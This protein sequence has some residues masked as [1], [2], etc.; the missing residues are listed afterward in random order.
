MVG[1]VACTPPTTPLRAGA[2][3]QLVAGGAQ[4]TT[5]GYQLGD[6]I[7]VVLHD[8]ANTPIA[9]APIHVS[10]DAVLGAVTVIDALTRADGTARLVWRLGLTVG[11]QQLVITSGAAA[12]ATPLTVSAS[13][14]S[15]AMRAI[16]GD[17][18]VF[19][20][21]DAGGRLGCWGP[22]EQVDQ[23]PRWH[24]HPG[25]QRFIA[26]AVHPRA[27]G[28]RRGC[29][30]EDTGRVWCFDVL[31]DATIAALS[32]MPGT[33]LPLVSVTTGSGSGAM[34]PPFCGL[35]S[36]G[37]AFC[38]GD[39][40][41]GTLGD[42]SET[43]RDDVA[44]VATLTRFDRIGVGTAHACATARDG[45]GWCWGR[46][47]MS[48]VGY[49][50]SS[51]PVS[52]PVR[53]TGL[54][55][56]NDVVPIP[57]DATC[58]VLVDNGGIYCW[59]AKSA[60]GIGTPAMELIDEPSFSFPVY[61]GGVGRDNGIMS[62]DQAAVMLGSD[63]ESSWWGR[64]EPGVERVMSYAPRPFVHQ[65]PLD[66]RAGGQLSGLLCGLVRGSSLYLCGRV[67]TLTGYPSHQLHPEFA[68][69][70]MPQP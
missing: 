5:A 65:L 3:L 34:A 27:N 16:A 31:G 45:T 60:T 26:L 47:Q 68:G 38:W 4:A 42:G 11:E 32:E 46:N 54:L 50:A 56:F 15:E 29:A 9:F 2:T 22:L 52:V 17:E 48:Q 67:M 14:R 24:A 7:V 70:G 53:R 66:R 33:H 36:D 61:T 44:P 37:V 12:A 43:S 40:T 55:R 69:F 63:G 28:T 1:V 30:V 39:N 25:A 51:F 19:C 23:A 57:G 20:G 18:Q 21:L 6:T 58:G 41:Y 35:T 10:T 59:G 49:T 62:V 64:L 8:D 13:A